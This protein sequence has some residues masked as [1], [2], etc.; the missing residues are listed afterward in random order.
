[1][2][3]F[4]ALGLVASSYLVYKM[5][6]R[7]RENNLLLIH[8]NS[9]LAK[10][11]KFITDHFLEMYADGLLYPGH[12]QTFLLELI[13]LI[14]KIFKKYL[15]FFKFKYAN[16]ETFNLKDGGTIVI[17]HT[18]CKGKGPKKE[19]NKILIVIPGFTSDSD[20]YYIKN[21][22]NDFVE[23]FDCR[24]MNVR[25]FGTKLTSPYMISTYSYN[26]VREYLEYT[27]LN[28]LDK[29]VFAVG[30]SFGGMLLA[31]CL[32]SAESLPSNLIGGCGI[33]YPMCLQS[34]KNHV[35]PQ[36]N[37][38]YSKYV[39]KSLK[40]CFLE[41]L[42]TI[43][44]S[45]FLSNDHVVM[46]EKESIIEKVKSLQHVAEFDEIF[47]YKILNF[48]SCED[49]YNDSKLAP[50]LEKIK[51]PF[52]SIFTKDDPIIPHEA[53]PLKLFQQNSNLIT[54]ISKK[55]GHMGFFKGLLP[56]RWIDTPIR[57]FIKTVEIIHNAED[58]SFC[59]SK[60]SSSNVLMNLEFYN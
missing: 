23:E 10:F 37:G 24:V 57:T 60:A 40:K 31:R 38:F 8:S 16:K 59:S 6:T 26:E 45:K 56:H 4:Y 20:E 2:K 27:C 50:Y 42:D 7:E 22:L 48:N 52:L 32:G 30:F 9:K 1:M 14:F 25:G 49:Y 53:I 11:F 43:F 15:N 51:I 3:F 34:T 58:L 33:C 55:G 39:S 35:E 36:L 18:K 19:K 28:N 41:N 47:T 44:S 21:F 54:I 5:K 29:N 46:K 17:D 12:L 13:G